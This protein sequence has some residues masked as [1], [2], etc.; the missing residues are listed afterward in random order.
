MQDVRNLMVK[1]GMNQQF[2]LRTKKINLLDCCK[3]IIISHL[4]L[5]GIFMKKKKDVIS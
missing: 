3:S 5:S 4:R 2:A 1:G